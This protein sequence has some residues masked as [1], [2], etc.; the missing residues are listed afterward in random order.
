VQKLC[1][2]VVFNASAYVNNF[3]P[4]LDT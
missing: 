2:Y 4:S 1:S 3:K